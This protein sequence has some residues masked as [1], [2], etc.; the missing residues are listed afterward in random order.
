MFN[1]HNPIIREY[2]QA[3]ADG[4]RHVLGFVC[5]TVQ[6]QIETVPDILADF[7]AKGP[8]SRYAFGWKADALQHYREHA[9]TIY[10]EAMARDRDAHA[11]TDYFASLPGLGLAKGGFAVQLCFGVSGC[12][13]SHNL[14]RLGI[15]PQRFSASAFKNLKGSRADRLSEYL[16]HVEA[17][18]GCAGLWDDWCDYVAALRPD[19]FETGSCV[20]ELHCSALGLGASSE[21]PF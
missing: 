17:A 14:N 21:I 5:A 20:S 13:D 10:G 15:N 1:S 7:E 3:S 4:M 2:A 11:L 12:L 6:Q 19:R 16:D 8:E 18:G 9:E